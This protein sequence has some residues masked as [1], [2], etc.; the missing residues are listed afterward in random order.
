MASADGRYVLIY[1]G[2]IYNY[3]EVRACWRGTGAATRLAKSSS[4]A[5]ARWG[6]DVLQRLRGMFALGIWDRQEKKLLLARD[7]LGREAALL[8]AARRGLIFASRPAS[9]LCYAPGLVA[10]VDAAGL[11][12]YLEAGYFPAP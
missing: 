3:R 6:K 2:E 5:Y 12:L 9:A 4:R 8:R 10:E 7:R 1:N 11:A